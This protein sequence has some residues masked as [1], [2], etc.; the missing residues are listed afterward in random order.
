[1]IPFKLIA[2]FFWPDA[3]VFGKQVLWAAQGECIHMAQVTGVFRYGVCLGAGMAEEEQ[4]RVFGQLFHPQEGSLNG[5]V[6][7][8][9]QLPALVLAAQVNEQCAGFQGRQGVAPAGAELL[10]GGQKHRH[11]PAALTLDF[12][13]RI[14]DGGGKKFLRVGALFHAFGTAGQGDDIAVLA[15]QIQ[16]GIRG[17]VQNGQD[18][19]ALDR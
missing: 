14:V 16:V 4:W 11:S 5:V 10:Q 9:G 18:F 19:P 2:L 12:Q 15:H 13:H 3:V 7:G 1:M 8:I 17:G 6:N